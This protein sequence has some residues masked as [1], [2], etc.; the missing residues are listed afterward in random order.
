MKTVKTG[1]DLLL[2]Y[3][4]CVIMCFMVFLSFL[5]VFTPALTEAVGYDAYVTNKDTG[6]SEKIYTHYY[7]DGE[8]TRKAEYEAQGVQVMTAQL[9]SE[10]SGAGA[11]VVFAAAQ[12]VCL[13]LFI[14]LVPHRLYKLGLQDG[15]DGMSYH[16]ARWL[17]PSLFPVAVSTVTFALLVLTKLQWIGDAGLTAYRYA[18][19]HLYGLQR[20][21]LGAGSDPAQITWAGILLGFL[22]AVLTI[23]SC[24]LLY[25]FGHRGYHPLT[26]LKNKIKYKED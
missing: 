20:L 14:A 15:E 23:I 13:A 16:T 5:A 11:V 8:D 9:R 24:G 26:A 22:P 21:I 17:L 19:Y 25:Y 7:A 3:V 4:V 10:L 18:N 1:F 2:R 12:A 6:R